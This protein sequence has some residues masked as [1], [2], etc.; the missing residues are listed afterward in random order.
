ME[1]S[2]EKPGFTQ[3]AGYCYVGALRKDGKTLIV[4]LLAMWMAE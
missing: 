2:A 1:L 4:A 3:D